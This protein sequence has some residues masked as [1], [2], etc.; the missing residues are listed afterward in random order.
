MLENT[1]HHHFFEM[2]QKAHSHTYAQTQG[3][4]SVCRNSMGKRTLECLQDLFSKKK[5]DQ[6]NTAPIF[7]WELPGLLNTHR[8]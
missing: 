1:T 3:S 8:R 7:V 5:T 6:G 2:C 4:L